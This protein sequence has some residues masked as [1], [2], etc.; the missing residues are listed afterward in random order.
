MRRKESMKIESIY[1][2]KSCIPTVA[3]WIYDEFI[4]N[5][6]PGITMEDLIS[7]LHERKHQEIPLT[8]V[9]IERSECIGTVSLVENDLKKRADLKPWLASLYVKPEYRKRGIGENLVGHVIAKTRSFGYKTL[10][11][12]TEYTGDYYRRLNWRFI[13]KTIDEFGLHTE[14]FEKN[15]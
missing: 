5:Q 3:K 6:R 7:R 15:V 1:E 9:V 8:Y 10:Y 2:N 12:R 4:V 13:Y 11:L 14:V